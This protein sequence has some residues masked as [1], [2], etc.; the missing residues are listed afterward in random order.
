MLSLVSPGNVISIKHFLREKVGIKKY[1]QIGHMTLMMRLAESRVG[2]GKNKN[3]TVSKDT[4]GMH[5]YC[6]KKRERAI[7]WVC[8]FVL[9][10]GL[11]Y[12][13]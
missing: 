11:V 13:P 3:K 12:P 5:I 8:I 4:T 9:K 10:P 1:L 6:K 7:L 2:Y